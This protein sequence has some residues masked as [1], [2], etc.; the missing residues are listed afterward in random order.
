MGGPIGQMSAPAR[1]T[2]RTQNKFEGLQE[3]T[4]EKAEPS[5]PK[6]GDIV[7]K[8]EKP[9]FSGFN[10]LLSKQNE[11]NAEANKGLSEYQKKLEESIK[12]HD[13]KP[14]PR[15]EGEPSAHTGEESKK[16]S[17]NHG[18]EKREGGERKPRTFDA[19]KEAQEDSD[20]GFEQVEG[21]KRRGGE[22]RRG[23]RG[24]KGGRGGFH[25]GD[26]D[27]ERRGPRKDDS[28]KTAIP[29][30]ASKPVTQKKE[31]PVKVTIPN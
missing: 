18:G 21:E 17:F 7:F 8:S 1:N 2:V 20:D 26:D 16:P 22:G 28:H 29:E 14:A 4:K 31:E 25:K 9:K 13:A 11:Q 15:K 12:I 19:P 23:G 3:E 10:R 6:T 27:Q 24:G 5:E 30:A